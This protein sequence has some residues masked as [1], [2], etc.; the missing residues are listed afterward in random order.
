[1]YHYTKPITSFGDDG[2]GE[3]YEKRKRLESARRRLLRG[4]GAFMDDNAAEE[5]WRELCAHRLFGEPDTM[6]EVTNQLWA[7]AAWLAW[8][9]GGSLL[10]EV[11]LYKCV[12]GTTKY[13]CYQ[14]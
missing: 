8:D 1:L 7:H 4:G 5:D 13:F 9:G 14:M 3:S 12:C 2:V 11:E 10:N 6:D